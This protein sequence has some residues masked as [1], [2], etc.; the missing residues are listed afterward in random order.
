MKM[1]STSRIVVFMDITEA[2]G[3]VGE[4]FEQRRKRGD[5]VDFEGT[6]W[7]E[8]YSIKQV[9]QS[10]DRPVDFALTRKT[11]EGKWGV[12]VTVY[13][14]LFDTDYGMTGLR[15]VLK[16]AIEQLHKAEVP[17]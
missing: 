2:N 12:V 9:R 11:D 7:G 17:S 5:F 3:L 10:L 13:A 4:Y 6:A 16:R 1:F 15:D 8:K 14:D